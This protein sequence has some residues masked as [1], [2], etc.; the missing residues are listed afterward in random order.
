MKKKLFSLKQIA[1][2]E[3]LFVFFFYQFYGI[4]T[5]PWKCSRRICN[6][7]KIFQSYFQIFYCDVQQVQEINTNEHPYIPLDLTKYYFLFLI[8]DRNLATLFW[9]TVPI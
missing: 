8:S 4:L 9:K 1:F 7:M 5:I 3:V 6:D 2:W